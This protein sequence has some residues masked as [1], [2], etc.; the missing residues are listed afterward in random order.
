[1]RTRSQLREGSG[2]GHLESLDVVTLREVS[3]R[4]PPGP[5]GGVRHLD[6]QARYLH[7]R[8][9]YGRS[10][11]LGPVLAVALVAGP[12]IA[13]LPLHAPAGSPAVSAAEAVTQALMALERLRAVDRAVE[14]AVGPSF[15]RVRAGSAEDHR[16]RPARCWPSRSPPAAARARAVPPARTM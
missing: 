4:A 11:M 2:R 15:R 8:S 14:R 13:V 9:R 1:M 5:R 16:E 12:R 10:G 6:F 3:R 7:Q